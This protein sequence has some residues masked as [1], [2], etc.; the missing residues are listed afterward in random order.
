MLLAGVLTP[1]LVGCPSPGCHHFLVLVMLIIG[2]LGAFIER[3]AYRPLRSAPRVSVIIT[4]LGCGLVIEN[5]T[6]SLKSPYSQSIPPIFSNTTIELFRVANPNVPA[7][8]PRSPSDSAIGDQLYGDRPDDG[9]GFP[10]PENTPTG[11][12]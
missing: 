6:L 5:L 3:V 12:P 1:L 10:H 7:P 8:P 9:L 4:A 11:W 2:T